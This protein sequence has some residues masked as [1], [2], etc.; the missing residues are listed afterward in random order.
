MFSHNPAGRRSSRKDYQ[1]AD[2]KPK[3][4]AFLCSTRQRVHCCRM[5]RRP[6]AGV[7]SKRPESTS[8]RMG[9]IKRMSCKRF[10]AQGKNLSCGTTETHRIYQGM[11]VFIRASTVAGGSG[12]CWCSLQK[13]GDRGSVCSSDV[14]AGTGRSLHQEHESEHWGALERIFFRAT[15]PQLRK[16]TILPQIPF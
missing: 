4:S 14:Q 9:V 6:K 3:G 8:Q 11:N 2:V 5:P 13:V 1:A 15:I 12:R 7:D 10:L 16:Q